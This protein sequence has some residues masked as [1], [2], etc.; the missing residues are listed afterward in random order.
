MKTVAN[1]TIS[2]IQVVIAK[3]PPGK[4][5]GNYSRDDNLSC[6]MSEVIHRAPLSGFLIFTVPR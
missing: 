4:R 3:R 1:V 2:V 5:D 6:C